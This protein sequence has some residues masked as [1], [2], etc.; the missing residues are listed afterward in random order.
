MISSDGN[1]L[2]AASR[3]YGVY[4]IDVSDPTNMFLF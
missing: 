1:Y 3:G 2:L 4:V